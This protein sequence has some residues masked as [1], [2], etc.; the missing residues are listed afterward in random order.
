MDLISLEQSTLCTVIDLLFNKAQCIDKV[1]D[2]IYSKHT[3]KK[4]LCVPMLCYDQQSGNTRPKQINI[5][6]NNNFLCQAMLIK[7]NLRYLE[8]ERLL[9][10]QESNYLV[11]AIKQYLQ[12][13]QAC[14]LLILP[15]AEI[16]GEACTLRQSVQKYSKRSF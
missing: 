8:R 7:Q 12:L 14:S 2:C 5:C 1:W 16:N 6:L 13:R 9:S 3:Q 11:A 10:L 4:W 15:R